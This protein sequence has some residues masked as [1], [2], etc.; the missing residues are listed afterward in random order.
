MWFSG[1]KYCH[2][3][4][5]CLFAVRAEN[6][7]HLAIPVFLHELVCRFC[8][9]MQFIVAKNFVTSKSQAL[10]PAKTKG[11]ILLRLSSVLC[12]PSGQPNGRESIVASGA[13]LPRELM[14]DH[15]FAEIYQSILSFYQLISVGCFAFC[16]WA[17]AN[18]WLPPS[19]GITLLI[20]GN[21]SSSVQ[22]LTN[23]LSTSL[24]VCN[25][26]EKVTDL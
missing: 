8:I 24:G 18:F 19:A 9:S 11:T 3:C 6:S 4:Y 12:M 5:Y 16:Q 1:I 26:V 21:Q 7:F 13:I 14:F 23:F 17:E 10:W 2:L 20:S 15:V 25:W 22:I